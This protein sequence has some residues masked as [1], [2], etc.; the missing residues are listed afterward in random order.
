V[1]EAL[2]ADD[3]LA[4]ELDADGAWRRASGMRGENVQARML[5]AA[6]RR[7]DR[8]PLSEMSETIARR[9]PEPEIPR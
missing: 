5:E 3:V 6:I 9:V 8:T 7:A 1:L 2:L 4:W